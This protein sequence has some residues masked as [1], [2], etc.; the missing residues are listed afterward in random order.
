MGG[1]VADLTII[2][3]ERTATLTRSKDKPFGK[4]SVKF[5]EGTRPVANQY[6]YTSELETV[7]SYQNLE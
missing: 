7:T 1:G 4:I 5:K 2:L 3:S 6:I